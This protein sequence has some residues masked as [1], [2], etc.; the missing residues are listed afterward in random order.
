[1]GPRVARRRQQRRGSEKPKTETGR[2]T[3]S[4]RNFFSRNK[5]L[6]LNATRAFFFHFFSSPFAAASNMRLDF[7]QHENHI[8]RSAPTFCAK[9]PPPLACRLVVRTFFQRFVAW[10]DFFVA[11]R[12]MDALELT[13]LVASASFILF[14]E[15]KWRS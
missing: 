9:N 4:R 13:S 2:K 8:S 12:R 1:M 5:N 11:F 15:T 14:L 3:S 10:L 7:I 6:R